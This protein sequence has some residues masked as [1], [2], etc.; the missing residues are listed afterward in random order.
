MLLFTAEFTFPKE[1]DFYFQ[2]KFNVYLSTYNY[3]NFNNK[4]IQYNCIINKY[5]YN[6]ITRSNAK[7]IDTQQNTFDT[8]KDEKL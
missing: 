3:M 8:I 6:D 5:T 1:Q 4:N 2:V 7:S